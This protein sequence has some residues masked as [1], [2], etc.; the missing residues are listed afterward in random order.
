MEWTATVPQA[1]ASLTQ[2]GLSRRGFLAG[3]ALAA[4]ALTR[5]APALALPPVERQLSGLMDR[6]WD[7]QQHR[8]PETIAA[9]GAAAVG[10]LTVH[11]DRWSRGA[12]DQWIDWARSAVRRIEAIDATGLPQ[13]AE[14]DRAVLLDHFGKIARMGTRYRFGATASDPGAPVAPFAISPVTGPHRALPALLAASGV[15]VG[16][17]GGWPTEAS[18][19]QLIALPRALD[20]ATL[21]FRHDAA[22]G[23]VPSAA[24]IDA[25]LGQLTALRGSARLPDGLARH[26]A[27]LVEPALDRQIAALA[28]VRPAAGRVTGAWALPEGEAF[29]ADALAWHTGAVVDPAEAHD[30][31]QAQVAGLAH[32]LAGLPRG[33]EVLP[34]PREDPT[35]LSMA[36]LAPIRRDGIR[37][38]GH[39]LGWS[40]H[41]ARLRDERGE[42]ADDPVRRARVLQEQLRHA[43]RLVADTGLHA[44]RWTPA[45]TAA[46]L[47]ETT[48]DPLPAMQREVERIAS[49]PGQAGAGAVGQ[50]EWRRLHDLTSRVSGGRC[51]ATALRSLLRHGPAPF[52]VLEQVAVARFT[53]R[54]SERDM[55]AV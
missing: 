51:D 1:D 25:T 38:A 22:T 8:F 35:D 7:E 42:W 47:A 55:R 4:A 33:G 34:V 17:G 2:S 41:A 18:F 29:Y 12:R 9:G 11:A 3:T 14:I 6:L 21:A 20:A 54:R 48:G 53:P 19:E 50:A 36:L 27:R 45:R 24:L 16:V 15:G 26:Y 32:Q 39:A 28:A 44:R 31:G 5:A 13:A 30:L 23:V 52:A 40:L 43:A 46:Y 49:A 37:Y 10:R